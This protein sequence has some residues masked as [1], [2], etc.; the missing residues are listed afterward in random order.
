MIGDKWF[1][2]RKRRREV[3][4]VKRSS[5]DTIFG[6]KRGER[7]YFVYDKWVGENLWVHHGNQGP[8]FARIE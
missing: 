3:T 8:G 1:N 6:N 2:K 7:L 4:E 5:R